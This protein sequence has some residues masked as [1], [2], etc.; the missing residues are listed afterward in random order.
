MGSDESLR[1]LAA[2]YQAGARLV[3]ALPPRLRYPVAAVGGSVWYATD[4]GRRRNALVNYA[5]VLGLPEG[6]PEVARVARHAFENYCR[7]L[8][9]FLLIGS[10]DPDEVA[11]RLRLEGIE[12][13]GQALDQGRGAILALPHMGSWDFAG[14]LAGI[15]GYR[16]MAVAETFPGSLNDAV[17][18]TRSLHGMDIVPLGRSA[19]H[20]INQALN[21]NGL[22]ALLCDLPHG[23]GV[24]VSFFGR[25]AVVPSGPAA[26]ARRRDVP[27]LPTYCRRLAEDSY[28][29]HVDPPVQL[30]D[31]EVYT[32]REGARELMQRVV[33]RFE[34]F[35]R[36][37]P[38]QWYAFRP[39]LAD[40]T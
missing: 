34:V 25:R 40:P 29:V 20:S 31:T 11:G 17:V 35:I 39:I 5:A 30:T 19:V 33:E 37:H 12:H 9:D 18:Q 21:Q 32:G 14:A 26:I 2:G 1:P 23:P 4:L 8:A 6:D 3:R 13:I 15:L 27:L 38:E 10:L 36:E 7:M 16:L 28:L 24:E 22:V